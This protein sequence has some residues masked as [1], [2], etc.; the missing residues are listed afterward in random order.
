[1]RLLGRDFR[2]GKVF[3]RLICPVQDAA[4]LVGLKVKPFLEGVTV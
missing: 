4:V 3:S 1:M 2:R